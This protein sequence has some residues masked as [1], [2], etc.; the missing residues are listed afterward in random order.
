MKERADVLAV[1]QGLAPTRAR[2]QAL[3]LAGRIYW[4]ERRIDKPGA[5]LPSDARL[6]LHGDERY[7]SRGGHKLEGALATLNIGVTDR[8]CA[9]IGASTGGFTDCLLQHGAKRVYAIDVGRAQLATKLRENPQVV[10]REQTNA[11]HLLPEHFEEPLDFIVVDASFIGIEKL[12]PAI[13]GL[14]A[15]GKDLLVLIKPQFQAGREEARRS[16]GVIRDPS[17]RQTIIDEARAAIVSAGF[18]IL[19]DSTSSLPG[20][21]GNVEHFTW[22]R[23]RA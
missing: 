2:A 22:A 14:L 15:P 12:L 5:Q 7:V 23:R 16:R 17:L 11:R 18:E 13:A 21:K 4:G 10:V 20:P 9:D 8:V 19:G 3:L 6:V 1:Q